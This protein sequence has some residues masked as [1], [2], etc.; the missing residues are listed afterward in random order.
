MTVIKRLSQTTESWLQ[1][2]GYSTENLNERVDNGAT[3]LIIASRE[4][5]IDVV[6]DLLAS[7]VH[8]NLKNNDGNNALWFACFSNH[9]DL[10]RL[11]I[12]AGIDLDNQN[13]NGVTVLMYAAS[14]GKTDAVKLLLAAG[15][16]P[17]LR[18]LDDFKAIDFSSTVEILKLLRKSASKSGNRN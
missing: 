7:D 1:K 14:A 4:G 10:M 9:F 13:D 6:R 15:A 11:L 12:N 8:I 17:H 5:A 18:N 3:A 16:N 2:K